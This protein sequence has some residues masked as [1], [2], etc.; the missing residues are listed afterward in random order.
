MKSV[1]SIWRKWDL[2]IHTPASFHWPGKK[3]GDQTDE[4]RKTTCRAIIERVNSLDVDAFCIMDYWTFDGYLAVRAY[5]EQNPGCTKKKIFPGVELRLEAPTNHRL[6]THVLFDDSILNETLAHF[7]ARLC[8]GNPAGR[9]PSRQNFIDLGRGYDAG[10]LRQHGFAPDDKTNDEKMLLLGMQTAVVTRE[11]LE[12]AVE[13]VGP[14]RCIVIQPYDTSD[15][16][17]DLDWKRHPYSDSYLM[18]MADMFETRHPVH[19]DLFLGFGHPDKPTL[20]SEFI[21]NLGGEPKPVVSGSDAHALDKYGV[22]PSN[23]ITWLKAQP[24]FAG[25][26]QVCHEPSIRCFIGTAPPKRDH[27]AQNPTKYMRSLQIEKIAGSSLADDWFDGIDVELNP[28]LIAIIGNKGT[29]KSA[30]ADILAL[31][32]NSHCPELE[33]LTAKRFR[34]GGNVAQYFRATL[35]WA[36]GKSAPVTLDEDADMDQPER[37]RYLP[38]QF[39]ENLCNEIEIGGGSFERELKKVIFSHV[40]EDRRLKKATLDELID[41]TV[42]AHRK[43]VSQMQTKL[44]G[45]NVDILRVERDISEDMI[46]SYRTALSLKQAERDAHDQTRPKE[47]AAPADEGQTDAEKKTAEDLASAQAEQTQ[48]N[49]QL[50]PLKAER[51]ALVAKKALLERLGGHLDNLE[52]WYAEFLD[53]NAAEFEQADLALADIASLAVNRDPVNSQVSATNDRLAEI[54]ALV[55]GSNHVK[56]LEEKADEIAKRIVRLQNDLGARQREYQA[57]LTD[58]QRWQARRA[59]IEGTPDKPDTIQYLTARIKAAEETLPTT[60]ATLKDQRKQLLREIHAELLKIRTVYQELY[61]PVQQMVSASN[62]FTKERLQLDFDAYLSAPRF[63]DDFLEYIHR[64][65]VGNFYGEEE[66]RRAVRKI[67]GTHDFNS[68]DE[69]VAFV[70]EVMAAL[71][72]VDRAGTKETITIQS[73]LKSAKRMDD[74]YDFIFGLRYLEPRYALKLG[75]KDISQ[76]SPGEKGALLL[77]FYLLLDPEEIPI[78]IDQPEQ[79][80]DNESVVKLL[81][82]CIRQ[83][84][85]RRQVVIVTH[86]P[87]LAVVCDADQVICCHLDKAHGNKVTYDSGAIEDNPINKTTVDVLEGTYPAFD[88]RRRKYHKPLPIAA[89]GSK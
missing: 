33:F 40:P 47:K 5:L 23:R 48:I 15:G 60:L 29:G 31:T 10:K 54:A 46:K 39:I 13:L 16:L 21:E 72:T 51:S 56:G 14:D 59:D 26:R 71:T 66:S 85:A 6:N 70:D 79:N 68:T 77:V 12:N 11:S 1:G 52:S 17:E 30:L 2:H 32:G 57:Y 25:L 22:Y 69:V 44:H 34:K 7:L 35:T 75:E 81:V 38:Q 89:G 20:G 84:R 9:P 87:N 42:G 78:I 64:N 63:E 19:V 3:L 73:Q 88:N 67:L 27:V 86:N 58:L 45:I 83:A 8:M 53:Q 24:T 28:G 36:D 49:E 55:S 76:L 74:L 65:K 43:A 82:D 50:T 80:L 18:K 61:K 62:A 41:Y 4:E 37:V